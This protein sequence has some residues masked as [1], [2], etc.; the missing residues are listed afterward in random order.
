LTEVKIDR[1]YVS[2]LTASAATRAIVT[3]IHQLATVMGLTVVAEGVE[4]VDTAAELATLPGAIGQGWH[5]GKPVP[6][7]IFTQQWLTR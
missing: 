2:E 3:S 6:V 4:D 7:D 5:F 1:T